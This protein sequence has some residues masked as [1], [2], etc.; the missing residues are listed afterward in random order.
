MG[1]RTG[2]GQERLLERTLEQVHSRSDCTVVRLTSGGLLPE[3]RRLQL[4]AGMTVTRDGSAETLAADIARTLPTASTTV[5]AA[6]R[7]D[8]LDE[9]ERLALLSL[10]SNRDAGV[11][12]LATSRS[13]SQ[14]W[15][16][17]HPLAVSTVHPLD[18][19]ETLR[20]LHEEEGLAIAPHV[21]ATLANQL[22][23]NV[24]AI[25]ET[26]AILDPDQRAGMRALPDPLPVTPA[27]DELFG[28]ALDSL[29]DGERTALL[30][31]SVAVW[32]RTDALLL[33]TG[34]DLVS[35]ISS[36]VAQHVHFVAGRFALVDPR[37][38]SL[39]HGRATIVE[40][41]RAHESLASAHRQL[42]DAGIEAWHTSLAALAGL[43][44]VV[45][46]LIDLA[47]DAL[48]RGDSVWAHQV[49][50][51]AASQ[52][53]DDDRVASEVVAGMAALH[54][55][56]VSDAVQWLGRVQRSGDV[57][58]SRRSL[59]AYVVAV[60]LAQ[61][62]VPEVEL[63]L[64]IDRVPAGGAL[65]VVTANAVGAALFAERGDATSAQRLLQSAR[66]IAVGVEGAEHVVELAQSWCSLFGTERTPAPPATSGSVATG[67]LQPYVAVCT[68]LALLAAGDV[69]AATSSLSSAALGLSR[70][71]AREASQATAATPFLEAHFAVAQSLAD[72]AAGKLS[73]AAERLDA[74]AFSGPVA[75]V[76]A[77]LGVSTARRLSVLRELALSPIASALESVYP[78]A[79]TA[80][81]RRQAHVDQAMAAAFASRT[82]DAPG[83]F[84]MVEAGAS[85]DLERV[86]PTI[87]EVRILVDGGHAAPAGEGTRSRDSAGTTPLALRTSLAL[88]PGLHAT[89]D[90]ASA[91]AASRD[92]RSPF[93]RALT[94]LALGTAMAEAGEAERSRGHRLAAVE[95]FADSG[96]T[97][98]TAWARA[99]LA[100][101]PAPA[102]E[103]VLR[104]DWAEGLTD[105]EFQVASLVVLGTTNR[106]VATSLHLSVRT[107]EVHL[108]RVFAKLDV[109]SRT[110]LSYRAHRRATDHVR[111][112][113]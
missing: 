41:T 27:T 2:C 99:R 15:R 20:L 17:P 37:I 64:A 60:T 77:G 59:P 63:Q 35:L 89:D 66:R 84:S 108:A 113:T 32:R 19:A 11:V 70:D 54:S 101:D 10:A 18:A 92:I 1:R 106:E 88:D 34:L 112:T 22:A 13:P 24:G 38:R 91:I 48:H 6:D 47:T 44:S 83:F 46:A 9:S 29:T 21:A 62:H 16:V 102:T 111:S 52:A 7:L 109:R 74:A 57:E 55:G 50:R 39:V 72:V 75:L 61:G 86:L 104:R 33:A 40:R 96:A 42:G 30:V 65:P 105:R 79:P 28:A 94:E 81:M 71:D 56:F 67:S 90:W 107:V 4:I 69:S 51:E 23:G 98:L 100:A 5:F 76:L 82:G 78:T 68:G 12:L 53:G 103:G 14:G 43:P 26:A 80:S 97:A 95:F 87:D 110:E 73:D 85:N 45:P 36:G 3:L 58:L 25:L 49:A 8:R 31:A 93:E